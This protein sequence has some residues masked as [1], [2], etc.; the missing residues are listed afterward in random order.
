M[1]VLESP[2]LPSRIIVDRFILYTVNDLNL[3]DSNTNKKCN[4]GKK[5]FNFNWEQMTFGSSLNNV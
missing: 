1:L 5:T 3:C 2:D 4:Y